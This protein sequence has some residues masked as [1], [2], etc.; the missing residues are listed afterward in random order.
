MEH[1]IPSP[2]R[3]TQ[4]FLAANAMD[5]G[6]FHAW[7]LAPGMGLGHRETWWGS[8]KPRPLAHEGVDLCCYRSPEG[9]LHRLEGGAR[10]PC[11]YPGRVVKVLP[12]YLG[13]SV[14]LEHPLETGI[15]LTLFGHTVIHPGLAVG[16]HLEA[17]ELFCAM[18]P[19]RASRTAPLAHLH[20][21]L[22]WSPGAVDYDRLD[23]SNL[24]DGQQV[25]L[26]DPGQILG[27]PWEDL[28]LEALAG[29]DHQL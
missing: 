7:A 8:L 2:S 1:A 16:Q 21:S 9:G 26:L 19:R 23:W 6:R 20:L 17:G 13:T 14:F 15:L 4:D 24:G 29:L 5:P 10:V 18:A 11:I 25:Q 28:P 12:D 22:A 3:F 27:A